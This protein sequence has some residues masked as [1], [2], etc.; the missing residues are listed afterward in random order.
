MPLGAEI[1]AFSHEVC[2]RGFCKRHDDVVRRGA[3]KEQQETVIG[4]CRRHLHTRNHESPAA[5]LTMKVWDA[6]RYRV[7]TRTGSRIFMY[8]QETP[9][10]RARLLCS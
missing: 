6:K 10:A 3:T 9:Q 5:R 2:G 4:K 7:C 8:L 1:A